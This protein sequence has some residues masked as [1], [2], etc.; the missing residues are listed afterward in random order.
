MNRHQLRPLLRPSHSRRVGLTM[1]LVLLTLPVRAH[2]GVAP[3]SSQQQVQ[4]ITAVAELVAPPT[5]VQA[6]LARDVGAP[7]PLR[8]AVSYPVEVT[9]AT[10]GT[11]ENLANGRLWRLRVTSAG[12]TDLNFGFTNF[13]LPQGAMLWISSESEQ[14][15][16]GPYTAEHN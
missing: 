15:Y 12:A 9:P 5:D 4:P 6:E 16:E 3:A 1:V 2:Q 14:Y 11:W 8:F 7:P 10:H 13:W